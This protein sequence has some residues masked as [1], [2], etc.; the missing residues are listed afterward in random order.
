MRVTSKVILDQEVNNKDI[1][2]V[3]LGINFLINKGLSDRRISESIKG[4]AQGG[5]VSPL[6]DSLSLE[7]WVEDSF[8]PLVKK[9]FLRDIHLVEQTSDMDEVSIRTTSS[10]PSSGKGSTSLTGDNQAKWKP[11]MPWQKKQ[12]QNIQN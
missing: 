9:I 3:G 12:V 4:Y 2:N 5:M 10:S 8:K 7:K 6:G 11:S 1:K